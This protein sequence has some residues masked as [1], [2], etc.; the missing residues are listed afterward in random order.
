MADRPKTKLDELYKHWKCDLKACMNYGYYCW[1]DSANDKHYTITTGNASHWVKAIPEF[2]SID[3]PSDQLHM[4]FMQQASQNKKKSNIQTTTSSH[5]NTINNFHLALPSSTP[6][7]SRRYSTISSPDHTPVGRRS[8]FRMPSTSPAQSDPDG[9]AE[10]DRYFAWLIRKYPADKDKLLQAKDKI[11]EED[12]DLKAIHTL[13][14][15]ILKS[16]SKTLGIVDKIC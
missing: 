12:L 14:I 11:H 16:W 2:A 6:Y 5:G 9:H 8:S 7:V 1:V 10:V 3:R 13:E 4:H 15:N